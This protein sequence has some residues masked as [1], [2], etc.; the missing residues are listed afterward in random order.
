MIEKMMI[1]LG[2]KNPLNSGGGMGTAM[3][4]RG[5][6]NIFKKKSPGVINSSGKA[7]WISEDSIMGKLIPIKCLKCNGGREIPS[8]MIEQVM[9]QSKARAP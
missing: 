2:A 5:P 3:I 4:Q 7:S 9:I 8:M 6:T 1:Q